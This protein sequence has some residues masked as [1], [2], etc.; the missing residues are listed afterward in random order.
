MPWSVFIPIVALIP[1]F[2]T[3]PLQRIK[4]Q[5]HVLIPNFVYTH[6]N[7]GAFSL[8]H[9][10]SLPMIKRRMPHV[11]DNSRISK[12]TNATIN[13][14]CNQASMIQCKHPSSIFIACQLQISQRSAPIHQLIDK[15][16][17][18]SAVVPEPQI[19]C[20]LRK[21]Q[22]RYRIRR[23]PNAASDKFA[24]KELPVLQQQA[25]SLTQ[26]RLA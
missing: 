10:S 23:L 4:L 15:H 9:L 24:D 13:F 7:T 25:K 22:V 6:V 26:T 12:L 20:P 2:P 16:R 3:K 14:K 17:K 11:A 21:M 18:T 1:I 8:L 5:I 19:A